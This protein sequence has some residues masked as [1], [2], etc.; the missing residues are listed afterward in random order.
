M[1]ATSFYLKCL[2]GYNG[3]MPQTFYSEIEADSITEANIS[4]AV[5][6]FHVRGLRPITGYL[7]SVYAANIKGRSEPYIIEITTLKNFEQILNFKKGS[8]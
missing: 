8:C 1:T 2:E 4:S 5:P 6:R 3:G 7:V